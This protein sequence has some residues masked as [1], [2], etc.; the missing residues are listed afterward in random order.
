MSTSGIDILKNKKFKY[1]LKF[2]D[3]TCPYCGGRLYID[4]YF[5]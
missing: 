2:E 3:N 4:T 1:A 5:E